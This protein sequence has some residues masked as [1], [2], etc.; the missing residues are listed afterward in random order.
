[1]A[2]IGELQAQAHRIAQD[3]G[4]WDEERSFPELLAL[5]HSELSE[6]LESYRKPTGNVPLQDEIAEELADC[7][8][9]IMDYC[10]AAGIDLA[11]AIRDK[12]RHNE[13]RA[14]RH[15]GKRI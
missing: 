9:R 14:H 13:Q 6:A 5:M 15:G 10:E 8:I 7:V 4:W 11:F 3:K 2:E 1:M 12:M